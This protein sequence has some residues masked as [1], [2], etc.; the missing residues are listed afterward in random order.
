MVSKLA[1]L[2]SLIYISGEDGITY[3]NLSSLLKLSTSELE[4][5]MNQLK[6]SFEH[7]DS[8]F[9]LMEYSDKVQIATK[10]ELNDLIKRY[11]QSDESISLTQTALETLTIIAYNQPITRVE[12]DDIR[13]VNS[14]KTVQRLLRQS[15]IATSGYKK[16]PGHPKLY[17]TT[18]NFL[19]LFGIK[20]LNELPKI[21]NEILLQ[22]EE[23][24]GTT[25]EDNG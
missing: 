3:D 8:P 21:D 14:S 1:Q 4:T 11:L 6:E 23:N 13:G 10:E 15:L 16:V 12:V 5:L 18:D 9:T 17:T 24:G 22:E 20:S 19:K 2:E 7:E 25:T